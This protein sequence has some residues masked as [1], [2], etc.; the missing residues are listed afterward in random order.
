MNIV[1]L[2][3]IPAEN[4]EIE[5]CIVFYGTNFFFFLWAI[6]KLK[7]IYCMYVYSRQLTLIQRNGSLLNSVR[8]NLGMYVTVTIS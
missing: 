7:S 1:A 6:A 2:P 5:N 8:T 4:F 3:N